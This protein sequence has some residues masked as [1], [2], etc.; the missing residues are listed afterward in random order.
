MRACWAVGEN[1]G[2]SSTR[3]RVIC[4]ELEA[5]LFLHSAASLYLRLHSFISP[6][7]LRRSRVHFF[8]EGVASAGGVTGIYQMI[9][10]ARRPV[11]TA[12]TVS[13]D[14]KVARV[15]STCT[16]G[17]CS[18]ERTATSAFGLARA[19]AMTQWWRPVLMQPTLRASRFESWRYAVM[20]QKYKESSPSVWHPRVP[21][22]RS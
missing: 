10:H 18:G 5:P 9:N 3:A 14:L 6:L 19:E 11:E 4:G 13:T 20:P 15:A 7:T 22:F 8:R 17:T 16:V 12:L 21:H 1:Q 2:S